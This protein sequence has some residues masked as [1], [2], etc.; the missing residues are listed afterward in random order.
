MILEDTEFLKC[1]AIPGPFT[2][3]EEIDIFM[4]SCQETKEKNSRMYREVRFHRMTS[5]RKKETDSVFRLKKDGKN[6]ETIDYASNLKSYLNKTKRLKSISIAELNTV[7]MGLH[8]AVTPV[9]SEA[10]KIVTLKNLA[11]GFEVGEHVASFWLDDDNTYKWYLGVITELCVDK[12]PNDLYVSYF[13]RASKSGTNWTY[14]EEAEIIKTNNEQIIGRRLTVS[15]HCYAMIRCSI[16]QKL[17]KEIDINFENA[18]K[19]I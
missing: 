13:I 14:P 2:S 10:Q 19:H 11:D 9:S 3:V 16:T 18:M 17:A 5:N 12:S 15:Y 4:K 1:Q 7:L 8:A 6:L